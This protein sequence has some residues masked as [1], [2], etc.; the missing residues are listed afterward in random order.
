MR[1]HIESTKSLFKLTLDNLPDGVLLVSTSRKIL[2]TN[3]AFSSIWHVP[4]SLLAE[5][6][7]PDLFKHVCSQTMDPDGFRS[8]VV[9]LY[10]S[11]ENSED[12]IL[13]KDGRILSRRSVPFFDETIGCARI[14]IFT[15]V[16]DAWHAEID[17]LTGLPNRRAYGRQFAGIAAQDDGL[18]SGVAIMD[19]DNF[20]AYNDLY[21]HAAGDAVLQKIGE[22]LLSRIEKTDAAFRIGGEEFLIAC[23]ARTDKGALTF[24]EAIRRAIE[25]EA[26]Q[27]QGNPPGNVVTASFGLAVFKGP[28]DPSR[29]FESVDRAL[30]ISKTCGRNQITLADP[31]V[32]IFGTSQDIAMS[33]GTASLAS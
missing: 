13:L 24:F 28:R 12:E 23:R 31:N 27:H 10:D 7:H 26:I 5:Q 6:H 8:E 16:T 33:A 18:V 30:Y 19:V 14:W 29:L 3:A 21:G 4:P 22:L 9:R 2:Y 15:D 17:S 1:V 11:T 25:G 32:L 20:K